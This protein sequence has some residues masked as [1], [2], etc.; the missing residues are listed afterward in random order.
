MS[1]P[2]LARLRKLCLEL[3][4]AREVEAWGA[5]TFRVKTIFASYVGPESPY[6]DG[7]ASVWVK[8]LQANQDLLLRADSERFFVPPY[9]GVRG[10]IGV[11]LDDVTEW[12]ELQELLWD[13]WRMSAP[14]KLA[15]QHPETPTP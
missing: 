7:R 12:G 8:T 1:L 4:E 10:W 13:A 6:S 9:V 11:Y 3:P 5:P 15:V 14:K 2:P